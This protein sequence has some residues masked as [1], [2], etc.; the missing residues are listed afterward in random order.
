MKT[1]EKEG[2]LKLIIKKENEYNKKY[3]EIS[4]RSKKYEELPGLED[5]K[6]VFFYGQFVNGQR[7]Y[8][9]LDSNDYVLTNDEN[10]YINTKNKFTREDLLK[11]S[12]E[13]IQNS[14]NPKH[15][16]LPVPRAYVEATKSLKPVEDKNNIGQFLIKEEP[17]TKFYKII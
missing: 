9:I 15:I 8:V 12:Q 10:I 5:G 17:K 3:I 2:K 7:K 6:K 14:K 13:Q 11:L 16:F 1:K 4:Y